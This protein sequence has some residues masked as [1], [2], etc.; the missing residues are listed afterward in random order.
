[1][2]N[3]ESQ[4]NFFN[5]IEVVEKMLAGFKLISLSIAELTF[6]FKPHT[7]I[8]MISEQGLRTSDSFYG[9]LNR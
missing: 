3:N 9:S 4:V 5:T 8:K 2:S 1:M 6:S 7:A